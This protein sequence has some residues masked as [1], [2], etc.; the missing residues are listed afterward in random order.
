MGGASGNAGTAIAVVP[1]GDIVVANS[2]QGTADFGT[3]GVTS[4]GTSDVFVAKYDAS[5]TR[6][7]GSP[8]PDQANPSPWTRSGTS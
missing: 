3:G 4:A 2:F 6:T 7:A 8:Q 1:N 5:W